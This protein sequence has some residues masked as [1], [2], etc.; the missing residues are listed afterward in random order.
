MLIGRAAISKCE[1]LGL[2]D[3][4]ARLAFQCR[5]AFERAATPVGQ[6]HRVLHRGAIVRYPYRPYRLFH[7]A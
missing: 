7:P 5:D 3:Y 2:P 4:V 1:L 6:S